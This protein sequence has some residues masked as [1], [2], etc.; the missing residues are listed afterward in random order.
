[1]IQR[2]TNPNHDKY[3]LYG[4]RGITV[5]PRWLEFK[6]F[7]DD[8]GDRPAGMTLDKINNFKGYSKDNCRW[9]DLSTQN[10]NRRPWTR[11]E[12]F[13]DVVNNNQYK[14]IDGAEE[15]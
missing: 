14:P 1:M 7:Y 9:A 6:N 15:F 13:E 3:H 8:M 10:S 12:D 4:G 5:D 2:C 11:V